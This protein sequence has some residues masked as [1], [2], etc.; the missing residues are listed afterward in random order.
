MYQCL[1]ILKYRS[2]SDC[3][4]VS[5]KPV[6]NQPVQLLGRGGI[7][8]AGKVTLGY[9]PSAFFFS[10][11]IYLEARSES[12]LIYIDDEVYINNN[13]CIISDGGGVYIGKRSMLGAQ[14]EIIDSDFHDLH[15]DRRISGGKPKTGRVVIGENVMIGSNVKILKGVHIG[16]NAIISNGSVVTRAVPPNT[17]AYGNPARAAFGLVPEDVPAT[18]TR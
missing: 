15:P 10:G 1:R 7:E 11:Y 14:C 16:D 6:T 9:F 12:A 18:Q 5:G 4:R 17:V 2:L 8:F 13:T 3:R